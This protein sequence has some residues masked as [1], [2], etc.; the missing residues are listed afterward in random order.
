MPR[1][2]RSVRR[3]LRARV[4]RCGSSPT[5]PKRR[6]AH[7]GLHPARRAFASPGGAPPRLTGPAPSGADREEG[8]TPGRAGTV[9]RHGRHPPQRAA[10]HLTAAACLRRSCRLATSR[11]LAASLILQPAAGHRVAPLRSLARGHRLARAAPPARQP[12]CH[13]ARPAVAPLPPCAVIAL[14]ARCPTL[15]AWQPPCAM[16]ALACEGRHCLRGA[17]PACEAR[18]CLRGTRPCLRSPSL[19]ARCPPRLRSSRLAR[20]AAA[21]PAGRR[22]SRPAT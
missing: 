10:G 16:P 20:G 9:R 14:R 1:S 11:P 8:R 4:R 7:G 19:P 12:P 18:L 17:R 15:P 2:T 22:G 13:L 5:A 21:L 3:S 6:P